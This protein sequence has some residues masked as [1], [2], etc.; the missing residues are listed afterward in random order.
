MTNLF[1]LTQRIEK[2]IELS[3]QCLDNILSLLDEDMARIN[4]RKIQLMDEF[5]ARRRELE[6]L[7]GMPQ[8]PL[9]ATKEESTD[10]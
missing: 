10:A 2:E 7:I 9:A 3:D 1:E 6:S 8:L 4:Q 5:A